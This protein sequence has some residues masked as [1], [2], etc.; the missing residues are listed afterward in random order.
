VRSGLPR[1]L[2]DGVDLPAVRAASARGRGELATALAC[3][4]AGGVLQHDPDDPQWMDRDRVIDGA[5]A[6]GTSGPGSWWSSALGRDALAL[7]L[8][9]GLSSSLDGGIFRVWCL[10]DETADDGRTWD[11]ARTA[12]AQACATLTVVTSGSPDVRVADLLRAAGW[13]TFA[14]TSDE[15]VEVLGAMD[16]AVAHRAGPTAVV[17]SR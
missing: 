3:L 1:S 2:L 11:A 17:L 6:L 10:L 8:G 12:A 4:R 16:R 14:A 7:A 5:G 9:A 15:P 13:P